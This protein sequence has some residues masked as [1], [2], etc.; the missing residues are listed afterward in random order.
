MI[1][2]FLPGDLNHYPLSSDEYQEAVRHLDEA[3]EL[4]WTYLV[5]GEP[6]VSSGYLMLTKWHARAWML[7]KEDLPL[8]RW[9]RPLQAMGEQIAV[10]R[11]PRLESFVEVGYPERVRLNRYLGFEVEGIL[12]NLF[13]AGRGGIVMAQPGGKYIEEEWI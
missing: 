4:G 7:W 8:F 1:R 11:V 10:M 13:G 2:R 5:S 12:S 9:R 6:L 3:M